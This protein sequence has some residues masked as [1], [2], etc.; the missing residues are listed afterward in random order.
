M[1]SRRIQDLLGLRYAPVAISFVQE[2]PEGISRVSKREPS[3]CA[4]WKLASTGGVFYA[5]VEDHFGCPIGAHI[6]GVPL[7]DEPAQQ[8]K[9]TLDMMH[10]LGYLTPEITDHLPRLSR[11][12]AVVVYAPLDKVALSPDVVIFLG[13]ARQL[14]VLIEA[15]Q[16][17][18]ISIL[19]TSGRPACGMIPT[20]LHANGVVTNLG[21]IGNR[22]YTQIGDDEFYVAVPG[23][24]LPEIERALPKLCEANCQL[25]H[26][27]LARRVTGVGI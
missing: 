6:Q 22:V 26:Y 17:A 21:C 23:T 14:M 27:H 4:Y 18:G 10:E 2:I 19:S 11:D 1:N 24:F 7:P 9:H 25:E 20:A 15:A 16:L 12:W 8:L 5:T 3:A 13:N